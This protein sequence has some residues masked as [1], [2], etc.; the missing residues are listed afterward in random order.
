MKVSYYE[1]NLDSLKRPLYYDRE[2]IL[3][4]IQRQSFRYVFYV[5]GSVKIG[6][7]DT[8]LI[9]LS[10]IATLSHQLSHSNEAKHLPAIVSPVLMNRGRRKDRKG[11]QEKEEQGRDQ[12]R[13][14]RLVV[15]CQGFCSI[16]VNTN[17]S[18]P[19]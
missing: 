15:V 13:F 12:D 8:H 2:G 16:S 14:M 5:P 1:V 19:H 6:V 4:R 17:P 10:W 18:E 11:K 9:S 7:L 3:V